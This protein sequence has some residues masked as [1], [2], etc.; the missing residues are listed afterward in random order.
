MY[1]GR[2]VAITAAVL[3]FSTP[4][5]A[6]RS[7]GVPLPHGYLTI[8]FVALLAAIV[9]LWPQNAVAPPVGPRPHITPGVVVAVIGSVLVWYALQRWMQVLAT[10]PYGA[11]MLIVIREATGRMLAGSNPYTTYR[12]YDAPWDFVLPYGPLLWGPY[13]LPRIWHVDLRVITIAGELFVPAAAVVTAAIEAGRG[14]LRSALAWL[15]LLAA[16]VASV[17]VTGFTQIGHTPVYWPLLVLF[18]WFVTRRRWSAAAL[19]LGLL[20][21]ARSTMVALVPVFLIVVWLRA[22]SEALRVT[23]LTAL[24]VVA[25]YGPFLWWN[26]GALWGN[27]VESYPRLVRTVVWPSPEHGIA[28]TL[29]TT[30]SLVVHGLEQWVV[31]TQIVVMIGV[32]AAAWRACRRGAAALPWMAAAL[33]AFSLTVLWPVYYI[34][35]DVLLLLAAGALTETLAHQ[36]S[37]RR[38]AIGLAGIGC[39]VTLAL[40][41]A[42]RTDPVLDFPAGSAQRV[43]AVPRRSTGAA[44]IEIAGDAG[45]EGLPPGAQHATLNGQDLGTATVPPDGSVMRFPAPASA[46]WTGFNRLELAP[47]STDGATFAVR[48]IAV[49]PS[50][51]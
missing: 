49:V 51:R 7:F 21:V 2:T 33:A 15:G 39:V 28:N 43:F 26:A 12:T 11:D 8:G 14:R 17:Q 47:T 18:A 1:V 35:F 31:P 46:W 50:Q 19:A 44:F 4:F 22:R 24:P 48:R 20:L 36:F 45:V 27:V 30:G 32:V 9:S 41:V 10:Q 25:L 13:L 37:V 5:V 34:H 29:G 38:W 3:L 42:I 40:F 23:M 6:L 16:L